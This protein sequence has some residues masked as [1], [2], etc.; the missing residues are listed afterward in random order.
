MSTQVLLSLPDEI[1]RKAERLASG[2]QRPIPGLLTEVLTEAIGAW[3]WEQQPVRNLPDAQLLAL[4]DGQ[5]ADAQSERLSELLDK[6]QADR[7]EPNERPEL[8]A[9][10]RVYE[11]GQYQKAEAL[12]EA[13]KR[14]LR[15]AGHP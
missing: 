3:D 11:V 15:P 14:G 13:V 9:L 10:M 1:Y 12:V 5:M 2:S 7:L 4:C 8:W 6:Q